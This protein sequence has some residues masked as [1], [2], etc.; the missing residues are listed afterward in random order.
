MIF[1][2]SKDLAPVA[3]SKM[4]SFKAKHQTRLKNGRFTPHEFNR[5]SPAAEQWLQLGKPTPDSLRR[6]KSL[7]DQFA[8]RS[9]K[10]STPTPKPAAIE[11]N[12][13]VT[14]DYPKS[15]APWQIWQR[16]VRL[17]SADATHYTGLEQT[18]K[19]WKYKKFLASKARHF[20]VVS[21]NSM[22]MS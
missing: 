3:R 18:S 17:I 20:K 1:F 9:V 6:L 22:A 2:T 4:N 13:L 5:K 8:R 16:C 15:D 10:H 7:S 21:F 12:P 11:K 14:F 19:G